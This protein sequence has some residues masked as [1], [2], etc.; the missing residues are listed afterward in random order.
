MSQLSHY[1]VLG[2]H[3]CNF[4]FMS[5]FNETNCVKDMVQLISLIITKDEA[6]F[7]LILNI[8]A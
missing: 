4:S 2:M 8:R 7:V 6:L 1:T 3:L 5:Y